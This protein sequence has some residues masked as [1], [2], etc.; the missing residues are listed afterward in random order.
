MKIRN[1]IFII[2]IIVLGT[3]FVSTFYGIELSSQKITTEIIE[4]TEDLSQNTMYNISKLMF[5][6]QSDIKQLSDIRN[7]ILHNPDITLESKVD[8]LRTIEKSNKSFT[9]ISLYDKNGIKIGNTR[10]IGIG[11]DDSDKLFF[12]SAMKDK[13]HIDS[14]PVFSSALNL[15]II[16][17]S[18]PFY[19]ENGIVNGIIMAEFP[20][21]KIISLINQN[22]HLISETNFDIVSN[23]G[24]VIFSKDKRELASSR[25]LNDVPIFNMI[26]NSQENIISI[27][28]TEQ[29]VLFVIVSQSG[30]MDYA[31]NNWYL[32]VSIPLEIALQDVNNFRNTSIIVTVALIMSCFIISI[33]FSRSITIPIILLQESFAKIVS[34]D[35]QAMSILKGSDEFHE[36]SKSFNIMTEDLKKNNELAKNEELLLKRQIG[37]T[38]QRYILEKELSE[39]NAKLASEKLFNIQKEEFSAM[40]SHEL[41]T[42]L[43]PIKMHCEMLKNPEMLG[44]LSAEQL[45]SVNEIEAMANK[46]SVLTDDIFDANKLNMK[47]MTF[48][49]KKF[50]LCDVLNKIIINCKPFTNKKQILL[51]MSA[52][53]LEIYTDYDR[54][55]QVFTN[56]IINSVDFVSVSGGEIH[57]DAKSKD[58]DILFSVKDNGS[59]IDPKILPHLFRKFYQTDTTLKRKHGG[60][61]LGLVICKGIVDGLGGNIWVE[62]EIGKGTTVFFTIPSDESNDYT[63]GVRN[64]ELKLDDYS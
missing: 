23:D 14:V 25:S 6:R 15:N 49:K 3:T 27:I 9:S 53:D 41:K 52:D 33:L 63:Y 5:E 36:L 7:P 40:V 57:I 21:N 8:Y 34:G 61:G 47:Q 2:I 64:S 30:H 42:P 51:T 26:K 11:T 17:F 1:S 39:S 43:F 10:N 56:L 48:T 45:E 22:E 44:K 50:K 4:K 16:H 13:H 54:L 32:F 60:T 55:S 31:G 19:D 35:L 38:Y 28:D 12:I 62:S 20:L 46:L 29:D 59:G 37:D 18:S 24:T 58:G